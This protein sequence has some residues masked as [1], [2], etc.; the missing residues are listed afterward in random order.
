VV[1]NFLNP[2]LEEV[3][4]WRRLERLVERVTG[5]RPANAAAASRHG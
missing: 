3:S 5:R 4:F 2:L 1:T